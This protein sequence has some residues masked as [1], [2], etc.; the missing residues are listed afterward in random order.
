M[1]YRHASGRQTLFWVCFTRVFRAGGK[2]MMVLVLF[3]LSRTVLAVLAIFIAAALF[4]IQPWQPLWY[5]K[6]GQIAVDYGVTV[7]FALFLIL[8]AE[9]FGSR[10]NRTSWDLKSAKRLS[11]IAFGMY[12]FWDVSVAGSHPTVELR[13][14]LA[15]V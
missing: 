15:A 9:Q 5:L 8:L 11:S 1:V 4:P 7:L 14:A 3:I 10:G 12:L 2:Q 13:P 6:A